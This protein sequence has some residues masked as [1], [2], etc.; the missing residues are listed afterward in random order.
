M[1]LKEG[2][3][4]MKNWAITLKEEIEKQTWTLEKPEGRK[5]RRL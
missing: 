1:T 4:P 3:G 5:T 2:V